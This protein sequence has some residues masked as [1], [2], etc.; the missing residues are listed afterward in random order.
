MRCFYSRCHLFLL[1]FFSIFLLEPCC[2][3]HQLECD[4]IRDQMLNKR[5]DLFSHAL[6]QSIPCHLLC[7]LHCTGPSQG[8]TTRALFSQLLHHVHQH[9]AIAMHVQNFRGRTQLHAAC[10]TRM[11][12]T[13]SMTPCHPIHPSSSQQPLEFR[14][15]LSSTLGLL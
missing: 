12:F 15:S 13:S 7:F 14:M 8:E 9:V 2:G 5:F 10:G 11:L 6:Q 1:L 4:G 3:S